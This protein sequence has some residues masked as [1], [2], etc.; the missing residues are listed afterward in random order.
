MNIGGG[1]A[2]EQL[3]RMMLS[4][5]EVAVRLGGSALKNILALTMAMSKNN[6]TISGK[7]NLGRML[8]ETRDIRRFP[9]TQAQYKQFRKTAKKYKL[10]YSTIHD[11]DGRGRLFDVVM[12]VT[13]LDRANMIFDR[14]LYAPPPEPER[15]Q[16]RQLQE[17]QEV[18]QPERKSPQRG[19]DGRQDMEQTREQQAP[20]GKDAPQPERRRL[21]RRTRRPPVQSRQ[22]RQKPGQEQSQRSR[23]QGRQESPAAQHQG[24]TQKKILGRD[25]TRTLSKPTPLHPKKSRLR[26]RRM[27]GPPLRSSSKSIGLSSIIQRSPLRPEPR[28]RPG[29]SRGDQ[30]LESGESQSI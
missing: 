21:S 15:Q 4:G 30:F 29:P 19:Q 18:F 28:P 6:K 5:T 8:Q 2:A 16:E 22:G 10:L 14:I 24:N 7:V 20:E 3:V 23:E 1:E 9:M 27:S 26:G 17:G 25:E 11:K 12:P 13:E